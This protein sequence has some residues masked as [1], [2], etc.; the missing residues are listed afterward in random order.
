MSGKEGIMETRIDIENRERE[1][2]RKE[3]KKKEHGKRE[4]KKKTIK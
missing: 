4:R 2:D 3:Q 1:G